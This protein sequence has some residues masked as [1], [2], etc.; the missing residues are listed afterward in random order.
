MTLSVANRIATLVILGVVVVAGAVVTITHPDTL[1]FKEY[2]NA[3]AVG[4]GLIGI[5]HGIDS[6][7]TP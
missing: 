1:S 2:V 7:S 6:K 4:G 5:A 3:V